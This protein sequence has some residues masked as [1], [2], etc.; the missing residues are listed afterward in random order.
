MAEKWTDRWK[1]MYKDRNIDNKYVSEITGNTEESIRVIT[2]QED[3]F[4]RWGKMVIEVHENPIKKV[5]NG[6]KK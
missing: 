3:K 4:P 5:K 1:Q 2:T 6:R